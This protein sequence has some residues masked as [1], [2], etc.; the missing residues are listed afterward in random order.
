[1]TRHAP[2]DVVGAPPYAG[3]ASTP[4][5]TAQPRLTALRQRRKST[6]GLHTQVAEL[7]D[8]TIKNDD[9]R[10]LGTGDLEK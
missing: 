8:R 7:L 1:M 6:A 10:R 5:K 2:T 3:S 9:K 4:N